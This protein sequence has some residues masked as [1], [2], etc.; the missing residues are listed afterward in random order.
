VQPSL[1]R[2]AQ[3]FFLGVGIVAVACAGVTAVY[4]ELYQWYQYSRFEDKIHAAQFSKAALAAE[5]VDLS[6]GGVIGKLDIPEIGISVIVFQG[7]EEAILRVGGGHVPGTPLPGAD[8]NS[9]IA[10]HRD[11]FFRKLEGIRAGARIRFSTVRA[12]VEYVVT[13][14]EIVNPDDTRALE[15]R[16]LPELTLISCYPFHFIGAA[17]YRFIVHAVPATL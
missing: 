16:G 15:S 4:A 2:S 8:G 3:R 11:T 17:P 9:A 14:T 13:S 12:T 5:P 10:G 6:E 1:M 7:V